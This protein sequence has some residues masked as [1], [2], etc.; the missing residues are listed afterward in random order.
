MAK[1]TRAQRKE[2]SLALSK[3]D[4][5]K[6][7]L[8]REDILLLRKHEREHEASVGQKLVKETELDL[9]VLFSG[10]EYLREFLEQDANR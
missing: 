9:Q 3:L 6:R 7:F 4:R 5:G 8:Q 2:L 1:L 10:I